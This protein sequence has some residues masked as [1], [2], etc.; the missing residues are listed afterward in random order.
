MKNY[1]AEQKRKIAVNTFMALATMAVCIVVAVITLSPQTYD[2]TQG[3]ISPET[4]TAPN[5][6]ID[7]AAT[8]RRREEAQANVQASYKIN[9]D[10]SSQIINNIEGDFTVFEQ[11]R[12]YAETLFIQEEKRKQNQAQEEIDAFIE[13]REVQ[14][15]AKTETSP[16]VNGSFTQA[17]D[18]AAPSPQ[19]TPYTVQE[20]DARNMDWQAFLTTEEMTDLKNMLPEYLDEQDILTILS[21]TK[22]DLSDLE[23]VTKRTAQKELDKGIM[24]EAV[25]N[26]RSSIS[27]EVVQRL[28]LTINQETVLNKLI[29]REVEP[30]M[31]FDEQKTQEEKDKAAEE[32][33]PVEYK[34]DQN[35]VQKGNVVTA[36]QYEL[37]RQQGLL[38][39]ESTSAQPYYAIVIYILLLFIM[40]V[41]FLAVFNMKLLGNIK[42]V[43][44]LCIL[45]A[46]AYI[47]TA[48]G[49]AI[50]PVVYPAFLFVI[51][52]AVLLSPKNAMVYSVFLTLLL[53]SVTPRDHYFMDGQSIVTI[54]STG[55]GSFFAIYMVK[56]MR[57]RTR[58]IAAGLIAAVPCAVV[59]L[60]MWLLNNINMQQMLINMAIVSGVSLLCGIASI[61]VLP[62]IESL[63]KLTTP[64]KLLEISSPNNPLMNKLMLQAPGTYHHS[65]LVANLAEAG[66]NAVGGFSLLARVGAYFHDIGKTENP[67]FFK[68]NQRNNYNPH[69]RLSYRDSAEILKKHVTDG[70]SILKKNNMPEEI[71][72]ICQQ[73]HGNSYTAYFYAKA[74]EENPDVP[75]EEFRYEGHPPTTKE[76][77]IVMLADVVEAAVRSLD[78]PSK[79]E[80]EEMTLKMIKDKYD[81]GQLDDAPLNRRDLNK[82]AKAFSNIFSGVYHQRIKYPEIKIHGTEDEDN[83]I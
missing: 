15:E 10:L 1:S 46:F 65:M 79:E 68:E 63:F 51:L 22:S 76:A 52:G 75:A 20:L 74:L 32:V 58:L 72:N 17:G 11:A 4:I 40:Y 27:S 43:A 73:H 71:I 45:T 39:S 26:A 5:D 34:K 67:Y 55:I 81:E 37:L 66:C 25:D 9:E 82:I 78:N 59:Q 19:P 69:D 12:A 64:T 54:L 56:D 16:P 29:N 77:A 44:I 70:V 23:S 31:V 24:E 21:M 47:I 30:N 80:I 60:L 83:V 48:V 42:K 57:Y 14:A 38:A 41:I 3:E 8:Q 49:Q 35:I 33:A 13:E 50:D 7:E 53:I 6:F 62:I 28:R 36:E 18:E 2:I 61:G